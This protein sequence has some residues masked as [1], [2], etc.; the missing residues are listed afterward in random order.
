M[1][2]GVLPASLRRTTAQTL[3]DWEEMH[4]IS[5]GVTSRWVIFA[6]YCRILAIL[7]PVRYLVWPW[8]LTK[9]TI[10]WSSAWQSFLALRKIQYAARTGQIVGWS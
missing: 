9:T 10:G 4:D 2:S 1:K 7:L 3:P 5:S 6:N 8:L